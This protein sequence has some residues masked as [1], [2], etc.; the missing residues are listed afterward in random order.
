[1]FSG[2]FTFD[3]TVRIVGGLLIA[4]GLIL[5]INRLSGVLLPFFIAWFI[6][7]MMNPLVNILQRK[8][9]HQRTVSVLVSMILVACVLTGAIMIFTASAAKEVEQVE[10]LIQQYSSSEG[11]NISPETKMWAEKIVTNINENKDKIMQKL[12][13]TLYNLLSSSL[14]YLAGLLVLF[15]IFL[16][17]FFLLNDFED[18]RTAW[19]GM[20]PKKYRP[21]MRQITSDLVTGMNIYFRKQALISL[22]VG[23][24]FGIGFKI[25]GLRMAFAMGFLIGVL[26]MVPYLHSLGL[27]PPILVAII[28][29]TQTG[30]SFWMYLLGIAIVFIIVQTTLDMVLTPKIMGHA[31]GMKPAVILLSLS[32]WGSL[33]GMLGMI[34]ALPVTT[35]IISYYKHFVVENKS[36]E[37]LL[38]NE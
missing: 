25:I 32:I 12:M 10:T 19:H 35:M 14:E 4:A 30:T 33:M 26:N 20:I 38:Q 17:I 28:Q 24:M 36:K 23:V 21:M 27:I 5:L 29:S 13:P 16:Y 22:I 11:Y 37:E 9:F 18:Y 1:M 6:A 3:R 7:Y 8:I 2:P 31:I 34:I 15:I